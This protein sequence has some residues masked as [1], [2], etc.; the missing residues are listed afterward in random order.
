MLNEEQIALMHR[1]L[2][3]VGAIAK[4]ALYSEERVSDVVGEAEYPLIK[5]AVDQ[6][7]VD[8]ASLF[9]ELRIFHQMFDAKLENFRHGRTGVVGSAQ[10]AESSEPRTGNGGQ[11][12]ADREDAR[13]SGPSGERAERPNTERVAKRTKRRPKPVDAGDD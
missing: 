2:T 11:P 9:A 6:H 3:L 7:D 4:H 1:H 13:G 8:V 5:Q 10:G 12:E